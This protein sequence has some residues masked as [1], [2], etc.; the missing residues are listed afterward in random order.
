MIGD[1]YGMSKQDEFEERK[2]RILY[3]I[4]KHRGRLEALTGC[5]MFEHMQDDRRVESAR[6]SGWRE[7]NRH[8]ENYDKDDEL[9]AL[10]KY[11]AQA[12]R[13]LK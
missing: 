7:A 2:R 11:M 12:N 9:K 10:K 5:G 4:G 6:V 8:P 3:Y 13:E 1:D